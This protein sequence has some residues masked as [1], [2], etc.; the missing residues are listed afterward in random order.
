MILGDGQAFK[1][2]RIGNVEIAGPLALAPMAGVTD[3][4]FRAL[5]RR[6]GA[7][8]TVTEMV[9]AKALVYGDKKTRELLRLAEGEHPAAVQIFGSEPEIMGEAA[10]IARELSGADVV[11]INMGC[12]VGKVV[13]NGDGCALMREPRKARRVIEAAVREAGCPVTVKLRKGWDKGSVNAVDFGKLCEDAGASAVCVH[14]RTRTQLYSGAADWDII[15]E[16]KKAVSIP[17]FANGDIF[18]ARDVLRVMQYTHCD[19]VAIGR[20]CFG[21]PWIFTAARAALAAK[22]AD[23]DIPI[24]DIPNVDFMPSVR[25]RVDTALEQ[26]HAAAEFKGQRVACL[27]A[28]RFFAWYLKGVPHAGYFREQIV[29]ISSLADAE[30]IAERIKREL[31]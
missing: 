21:N 18:S 15:R 16:V 4:A 19:G 5:C 1:M 10:S 22:S 28:R 11:D 30:A 26:L 8:Y 14:G 25:I 23:E 12:P 17:V 2:I 6:A 3:A 24:G 31:K 13:K 9:S 29:K 20:G 7:D 27:E